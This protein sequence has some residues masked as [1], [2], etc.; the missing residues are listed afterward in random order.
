MKFFIYLLIYFP[1]MQTIA[2]TEMTHH[3]KLEM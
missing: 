2:K 3:V 1:N